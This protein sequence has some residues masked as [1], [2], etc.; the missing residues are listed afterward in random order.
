MFRSW[1]ECLP[2]DST[3]PHARQNAGRMSGFNGKRILVTG[4]TGMVGANLVRHL[5]D[6]GAEV[7]AIVRAQSPRWR[8]RDV[9]GDMQLHDGDLRDAERVR[10][11][12][13]A[14]RPEIIYHLATSRTVATPG[15]RMATI[16][17][18]IEGTQNLVEAT[19]CL[20][21]ERFI[22]AGS[23]LATGKH[24]HPLDED[25]PPRPSNF[26]GATK[27]AATLLAQQ[28]AR[29]AGKPL[30]VLRIF[31]V[32]GYWESPHRLIP[33]AI[34]AAI[35][36]RPMSL[37]IPGL[38]RD[39]VFVEDVVEVLC[40]AAGAARLEPGELLHIGTG[41][42]SANEETIRTIEEACGRRIRVTGTDYPPR[43]SDTANWVSD[44]ARAEALLG[45]RARH[46]LAEGIGKTVK[47]M[48]ANRDA[49]ATGGDGQVLA[50]SAT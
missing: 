11:I 26:F 8:I 17:T 15:E 36:D 41:V 24:D 20:D 31:S 40:L 1:Q 6:S 49:Y 10:S 32:Y 27:A 18:N 39:L 33:T 47:W 50:G 2:P 45:W 7:H 42:Q 3:N 30:V 46:S 48:I 19:A 44:P 12:V 13:S 21:Y 29:S 38:R 9:S 23:S 4:A 14:A 34:L 25:L 22:L 28:F 35:D 43:D 16:R 37:T 5:L